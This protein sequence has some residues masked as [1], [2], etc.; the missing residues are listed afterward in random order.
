M[1]WPKHLAHRAPLAV[2]ATLRTEY[3]AKGSGRRMIGPRILIPSPIRDGT[4][5]AMQFI[6]KYHTTRFFR[7]IHFSGTCLIYRGLCAVVEIIR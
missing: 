4:T 1:T 6:N 7:V 5:R 3:G 2:T